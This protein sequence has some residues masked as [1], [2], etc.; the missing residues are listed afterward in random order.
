MYRSVI[1]LLL[2]VC[3]AHSEIIPSD[4]RVVWEGNVGIPGGIPIRSTIFSNVF[5]ITSNGSV[6]VQTELQSILDACP[7]NQ[8]VFI[9][10]GIYRINSTL[11]LNSYKTLRG[12]GTNTQ[13]QFYG[14][15]N[16]IDF[17]ASDNT[18][19][20]GPYYSVIGSPIK[21]VTNLSLSGTGILITNGNLLFLDRT[22][23]HTGTNIL[24][25]TPFGTNF[26]F[27]VAGGTGQQCDH[28]SRAN[29]TRASSQVVEITGV[30][31][32]TNITFWPPLYWNLTNTGNPEASAYAPSSQ[33]SG[34]EDL[35]ISVMESGGGDSFLLNGSK[36]CWVKNVES[37]YTDGDHV[38]VRE[39]YRLEV[40]DSYFH[41]CF[42][43]T[44]PGQ[45]ES[46]L[47]WGDSSG[48]LYENN[49]IRRTFIGMYANWGSAGNV[50]AYNFITNSFNSANNAM[51]G[52]LNWHGAHC[53]MNL[54]EGNALN[55][56]NQDGVWGSASHE[57]LLRNFVSGVET[58]T[59]PGS[60]R[61]N[62]QSSPVYYPFYARTPLFLAWNTRRFNLVG[63]V[64]GASG[65]VTNWINLLGPGNG[66]PFLSVFR[67]TPPGP[68]PT[69][70]YETAIWTDGWWA[71]GSG[72]HENSNAWNTLLRHGNWDVVR[73]SNEWDVAISD[74]NIPVSYYLPSKPSWFGN[75]TWPAMDSE[76]GTPT[77]TP[78]Q[79]R[80][81]NGT[82]PPA[83]NPPAGDFVTG[84]RPSRIHPRLRLSQ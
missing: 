84:T 83:D 18:A 41:D 82:N 17:S 74:H 34:V 52:S 19:R 70:E 65:F 37:D 45:R 54:F 76:N 39:C 43:H 28:C 8:V 64:I 7:S 44:S 9:P 21:G 78:A 47:M 63:N 38:Q 81:L 56:F 10:N 22:N 62:E 60:G 26:F 25:T 69:Y 31:S 46:S 15:A 48:C 79:Y 80:W 67:K 68:D 30:S 42:N 75:L 61:S 2:F 77:L 29:G 72:Y 1:I 66:S 49:I 50:F 59:P 51:Y 40:R 3:S 16:K 4:R 55:R 11:T 35:K 73:N 6:N 27:T 5:N 36:Y 20:T 53:M 14:N 33:W 12:N 23:D 32:G 13:L 58:W 71:D 24:Q 57:T